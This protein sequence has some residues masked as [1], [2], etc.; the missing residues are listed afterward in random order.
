MVRRVDSALLDYEQ[1]VAVAADEGIDMANK[2]HGAFE[3][4]LDCALYWGQ[5]GKRYAPGL[6]MR[7]NIWVYQITL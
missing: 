4:H 7:L 1:T 6:P 2:A 5:T 3:P